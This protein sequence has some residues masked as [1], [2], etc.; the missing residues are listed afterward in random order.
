MEVTEEMYWCEK[1]QLRR[2]LTEK[3]GEGYAGQQHE[4]GQ[5]RVLTRTFFLVL[6]VKC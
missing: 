5:D 4:K 1:K 2:V 3:I 6:N